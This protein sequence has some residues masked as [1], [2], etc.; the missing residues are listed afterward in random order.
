MATLRQKE[1]DEILNNDRTMN[2]RVLD[3]TISQVASFNDE[4]SAPNTQ[5]I[6]LEAI[7]GSLV[8]DLKASIAEA[9]KLVAAKQFPKVTNSNASAL[10]VNDDGKNGVTANPPNQNAIARLNN[11][12]G[13]ASDFKLNYS[14]VSGLGKPMTGGDK[15]FETAILNSK[16]KKIRNDDDDNQGYRITGPLTDS[17]EKR[18]NDDLEYL[19]S[20]E[21]VNIEEEDEEPIEGGYCGSGYGMGY[22]MGFGIRRR[23]RRMAGAG[24]T[25]TMKSATVAKSTTQIE[26]TVE[27]ALYD[28]INKYNGIVDK[29]LQ[30]TREGGVLK[31]KRLASASIVSFM[32]NVLKGLIEPLKHLLYE[33]ALVKDKDTASMWTMM[34]SLVDN[35]QNAPP[36]QKVDFRIYRT[37]AT[38]YQR[39]NRDLRIDNYDGKLAEMKKQGQD[40]EKSLKRL[41]QD[42]SH[43]EYAMEGKTDEYKKEM[44][45]RLFNKQKEIMEAIKQQKEDM[46]YVQKRKETGLPYDSEALKGTQ[47]GI[48]LSDVKSELVD[49]KAMR[50]RLPNIT[51]N[52]VDKTLTYIVDFVKDLKNQANALRQKAT[53]QVLTES[54]VELL[55]TLIQKADEAKE[56]LVNVG[57]R[58]TQVY[59][60]DKATAQAKGILGK[61]DEPARIA[62]KTLEDLLNKTRVDL[63]KI[64]E[65][66]NDTFTISISANGEANVEGPPPVDIEGMPPPGDRNEVLSQSFR[67]IEGNPLNK[68]TGKGKPKA[69]LLAKPKQQYNSMQRPITDDD[70]AHKEVVARNQKWQVS[71]PVHTTPI[72]SKNPFYAQQPDAKY[73]FRTILGKENSVLYPKTNALGADVSLLQGEIGGPSESVKEKRKYKK[74]VKE[75]RSAAD[76]LRNILNQNVYEGGAKKQPGSLRKL[77]FEDEDN[78]LFDEEELPVNKGF[79]KEDKDDKFK[80]PDVKKEQA[81][82]RKG[83]L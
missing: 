80:L 63:D 82:K 73:D 6:K 52:E 75:T 8:D 22:G 4:R 33:L 5:D 78:D 71:N 15:S 50:T 19:D 14:G 38:D 2:R 46:A 59:A 57:T 48:L 37:P 62:K 20:D 43:I 34:K 39:L 27:N 12:Q 28:I 51:L 9:L 70:K 29:I 56:K 25:T 61:I 21:D 45:A 55:K 66:M 72:G 74:P 13:T 17:Y 81:K 47:T 30:A 18:I 67:D 64:S 11:N 69:D 35:I 24:P 53:S 31:N 42:A 23:K 54:E 44:K 65:S 32:D 41:H 76:A 60:R 49:L 58:L 77:V 10:L 1:I 40:L 3:R 83:R 26:N 36:F 79:I 7:I 68:K 16:Q